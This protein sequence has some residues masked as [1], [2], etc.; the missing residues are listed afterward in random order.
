MAPQ[1][2]LEPSRKPGPKP[3]Q[4]SSPKRQYLI[5]YNFVSA[6]LWFTILGR[7][8]LLVPLVGFGNV[9][10]G[11]GRFCKWT[12]TL[13]LLEVVHAA[14]GIVRA[15]IST[16]AMQVAS[17]LLLVWGVVD[18]FP[19]L[20]RS[21]GYSSMLIAWSVTEVVRYSYFVFTLSGYSP[22]IISWLRYNTFYVL[23]PLGISSEC[24]LIWSAI[25][26][27]AEKRQEFAWALQLILLIYIPGSYVLFTHMMAQRRKVMRGKQMQKAE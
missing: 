4:S 24:W 5:L 21:A 10:P 23:Y 26:P 1:P 27:A 19:L 13:A 18:Q 3:L 8:V 20:A 16:T 9:Y 6:V 17:R 2:E 15:P 25:K 14:T 22:G 11:V 7:V 12:Q